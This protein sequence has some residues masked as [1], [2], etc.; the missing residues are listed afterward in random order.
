MGSPG[1][2]IFEIEL[3]TTS[4]ISREEHP[5]SGFRSLSRSELGPGS[6]CGRYVIAEILA[7]GDITI[8]ERNY[9]VIW[10]IVIIRRL[11]EIY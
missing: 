10:R 11:L 5:M 4:A 9:D 7:F 8:R 1:G 6:Y 2:Y 3:F